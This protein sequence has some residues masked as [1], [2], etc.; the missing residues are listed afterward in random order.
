MDELATAARQSDEG[1]AVGQLAVALGLHIT[2]I[3]FHLE[4]LVDAGLVTE[5]HESGG[6][7]GRPRKLY[8]AAV[9]QLD[10]V[11]TARSFRMLSELLSESFGTGPDGKPSTPEQAG[12]R[13]G[14]HQAQELLGEVSDVPAVTAGQ[15]LGKVGA[16]VDVLGGWGYRPSVS[17][18]GDGRS[19]VVD[20]VDCPFLELAHSNPAVVCGVHRG[21]MRGVLDTLGEK[22]VELRLQPFVTQRTCRAKLRT[23]TPFRS[24]GDPNP[25]ADPQS[26]ASSDARTQSG[27][28]SS[29]K[30][31]NR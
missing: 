30:E 1:V 4:Q 13:W 7:V 24:T 2:T 5:S 26:M 20:L 23:R 9:G 29:S 19:A 3:R 16:M 22:D 14:A 28:Y 10:E 6:R 12:A 15:W 21:L 31:N 17:T 27:Q 25:A 8:A 18:G 11:S